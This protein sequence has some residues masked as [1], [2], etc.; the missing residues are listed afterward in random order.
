M[1]RHELMI[2]EAATI[3]GG[4]SQLAAVL[5]VSRATL[6][7]WME[8][9]KHTIYWYEE[10][11]EDIS[12][13]INHIIVEKEVLSVGVPDPRDIRCG[14]VYCVSNGSEMKIGKTKNPAQR[15]REVE[16][17]FIRGATREYLSPFVAD[18]NALEQLALKKF[19]EYQVIGEV[20]R[21]RF[22][23]AV[24]FISRNVKPPGA[25][26]RKRKPSGD[27]IIKEI[28]RKMGGK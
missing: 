26:V 23:E 11:L 4:M 1:Q 13:F 3:F 12:S 22:D 8:G 19:S 16:T 18:C 15:I 2:E 24:D 14:Y 7:N 21:D 27:R 17:G 28:Q 10:D 5:G 25:G 9:D 6:Y 20:F